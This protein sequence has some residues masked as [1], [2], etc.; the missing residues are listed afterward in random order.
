[1]RINLLIIVASVGALFASSANAG[2]IPTFDA[3]QAMNMVRTIE[4]DATKIAALQAQVESW[5]Q[6]IAMSTGTRGMG[7]LAK[8]HAAQN[9]PGTWSSILQQVKNQSGS[10]GD[11]VS[12]INKEIAVLTPEQQARM[13]PAQADIIIRSRNLAAMQ[14]ATSEMTTT[15][16]A[17]QLQEIQALTNQI[18]QANDP[19]AIADLNAALNA[20]K[21]E[22]ANTQIQIYAQDQRIQAEQKAIEQVRQENAQDLIDTSKPS[23]LH[24]N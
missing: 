2:G 16:A 11:L 13:S 1:M 20:K 15:V 14:R 8:V 10:V 6:Q 24:F 17:G 18:D 4:N 22:L 3:A 5:K 23:R 9:L 12:S 21:L 19:K 7:T